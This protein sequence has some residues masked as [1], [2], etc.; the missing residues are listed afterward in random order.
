MAKALTTLENSDLK[1]VSWD[2]ILSYWPN[3]LKANDCPAEDCRSMWHRGRVIYEQNQ[4]VETVD[5]DRQPESAKSIESLVVTI[6]CSACDKQEVISAVAE[7]AKAVGLDA[8]EDRTVG[9]K[10]SQS[11]QWE[12]DREG[13]SLEVKLTQK[14]N[15]WTAYVRVARQLLHFDSPR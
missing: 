8:P 9:L 2:R 15:V 5:I 3:E 7:F 14:R 13:F 4:C 1:D 6:Y 12:R 10:P 11:F